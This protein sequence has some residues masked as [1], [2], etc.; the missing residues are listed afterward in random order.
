MKLTMLWSVLLIGA[1]CS[2]AW[3]Q[4]TA[5]INGTVK[6]Q[7]AAILP[8]VEI[9]VTQTDT[10]AA[11]NAVSDE[12]GSFVLPNLPIGPYKLEASLPGFRSY[13]QTGIVLQVNDKPAVNIT[14]QVG[15]VSEQVEVQAN[16]ALVETRNAGVG[17]VIENQ[18]ILELP[19]NGRQATDLIVLAGAAVQTGTSTTRSWQ[20][21]P[22]IS[23]AG[24]VDINTAFVLDGAL[25]NNSYDN[26]AMPLPFPDALQEFKVETSAMAA[27]YGMYSGGTVSAVTKSGAN[28]F[29]GD[30]FEFV[31]NDLFNARNFFATQHGTLKRNQF[32]GT[33]G[34]RIIQNK[35][36]FFGGY[37]GTILRQDPASTV[38]FVPTPAMMSGDFTAI[39]SPTCNRGRQI[40]LTAPF[41]NNR[42]DPT[43]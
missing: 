35:V 8:G 41:V 42:L 9:T 32:G 27:Q 4:A 2:D 37:Q 24:G 43:L 7:S 17:Q 12:A 3:S 33:L 29:H 25:H 14:L 16:A 23:V 1:F 36:F 18:R 30:L 21:V 26:L 10:G 6:D 22:T 19:L 34:G 40:N 5:Q 39:T 28:D 13:V 11:R 20:G 38:A 15:Q 31:R